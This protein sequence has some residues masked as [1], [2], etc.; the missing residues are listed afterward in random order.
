MDLSR[1][2][3]LR[4]S[5]AAAGS[6]GMAG[7]VS[8]ALRQSKMPKRPFGKT[9]FQASIYT[10]GTAEVPS[11]QAA[12][13]ALRALFAGGVNMVDTAPSYM[14][15]QSEAT[16]GKAIEGRREGLWISTKTLERTADGAY[17][18][19]KESLERLKCGHVDLLQ[20]HAVNDQET[21]DVVLRKGG[22]VE[23]L[24]RARREG[25]VRHIGITGHTR[26]EVILDAM[27][28]YAFASVL[29]PVS[30]L[31]RHIND[32]AT[33]VLPYANEHGVAVV[34]MK[35]LKGIERATPGKFDAEEYLRYALSKPIA[36]LNLG[37]RRPEEA[38]QNLALIKAFKPM[39]QDEATD[40]ER[41]A[42]EHA[43]VN[44]LWWK[45]T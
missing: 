41:R 21:L 43:N 3:F 34:G 39:T 37:L 7:L 36:T 10:V 18:E 14:G 27:K 28:K 13:D 5:A 20:V 42:R 30:A 2:E 44:T 4:R 1:R 8:R 9:G 32:F 22:A 38:V 29:V 26:P 45:R 6:V 23:G 25:L 12:V 35:A 11:S 19:V 17:R 31:D 15:T 16:V 40:L 24:E 33:E